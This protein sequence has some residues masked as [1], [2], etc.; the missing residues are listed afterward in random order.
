MKS[1][2]ASIIIVTYNHK[3]YLSDCLE[4]VINQDYPHE[5]IVV[6]NNSKDGTIEYLEKYFPKVKLVKSKNNLGFGAANNLGVGHS[7][8]DYIVFLNPDTVVEKSW[9]RKLIEPIEDDKNIV[10]TSKIMN[11]DG[12]YVNTCGLITHFTGITFPRGYGEKPEKFDKYEY[13]NSI[14]GCCFGI[15]KQEFNKIGGFDENF[16]LYNEDS[17]FSWRLK[18]KGYKILFTP[19]SIVKHDYKLELKP[20]KLYHLEKNRYLMIRKYFLKREIIKILPSLIFAEILSFGYSF[21]LGF[22]GLKFKIKSVIDGL[23]S[24]INHFENDF[25]NTLLINSLD[26]TIPYYRISKYKFE[27]TFKNIANKLFNYNFRNFKK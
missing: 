10:T 16:F 21:T 13:L 3:K 6:D 24:N 19:E 17:E 14:S 26:S 18:L 2:T 1:P 27:N 25:N 8:G 11:Y 4:S 15:K 7:N 22:K 12:N 9:L 23:S 5:I 20:S